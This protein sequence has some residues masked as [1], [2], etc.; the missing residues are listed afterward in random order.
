MLLEIREGSFAFD[1]DKPLL[2]QANL[3]IEAGQHTCLVGESGTGKSTVL[4][5]LANLLSLDQ[6]QVFFQDKPVDDYDYSDYRRQVSYVMQNPSLF[7]KTVRD[8]LAFPASIR[9]LEFAEA[10]ALSYM[11]RFHLRGISL[12][13]P[14][15]ELSGGEAQRVGLIRNLLYPPRVLLLDEVTASLDQSNAENVWQQLLPLAEAQDMTLVWVSH[16]PEERQYAQQSIEI[17]A[18]C[19]CFERIA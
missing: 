15:A 19:A 13:Q 10:E 18:A 6:G 8:N 7:G 4:K 9:D 5:I 12:D 1:Q 16:K 11:E 14:V 3:Q 17:K 2:K